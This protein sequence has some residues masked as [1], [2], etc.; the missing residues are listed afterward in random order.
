[1]KVIIRQKAG[2]STRDGQVFP[3][4]AEAEFDD[5]VAAKL[6]SYGIAYPAP[7]P[8]AKPKPAPKPAPPVETAERAPAENTAKRTSKPKPRKEA[9]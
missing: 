7:V 1:M 2:Y 6:I 5:A 3:C 8:A 4:G 9:K